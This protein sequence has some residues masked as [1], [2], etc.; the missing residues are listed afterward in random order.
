MARRGQGRAVLVGVLVVA[1]VVL[2]LFLLGWAAGEA[3]PTP[4]I[5]PR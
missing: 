1:G 4:H 2:L 5:G 3:T